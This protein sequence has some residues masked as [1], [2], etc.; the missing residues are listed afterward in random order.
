MPFLQNYGIAVSKNGYS[1]RKSFSAE[2][3]LFH[4]KQNKHSFFEGNFYFELDFILS[5]VKLIEIFFNHEKQGFLLWQDK[6]AETMIN[7]AL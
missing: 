6:T 3:P 1:G 2:Y 7:Y 4:I 5:A